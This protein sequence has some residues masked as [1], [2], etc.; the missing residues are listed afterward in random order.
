MLGGPAAPPPAGGQP[1]APSARPAPAATAVAFTPLAS[2]A[3]Y[4]ADLAAPAL[5]LA[6]TAAQAARLAR[7][8]GQPEVEER[9]AAVDF[10]ASRVLGV[11]AGPMGSSGHGIAVAAIHAGRDAVQVSVVLSQPRPGQNVAD[12]ITYPYAIVAVPRAA[13]P[14]SAATQWSVVTADGRRLV[15]GIAA[16]PED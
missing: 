5:L 7:L 6:A 9:L 3:A 16:L 15:E 14:P 11:F 2:G 4:T 1:P 8:T 10:A 12:V 13:L